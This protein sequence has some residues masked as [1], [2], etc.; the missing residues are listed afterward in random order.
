MLKFVLLKWDEVE[1]EEEE[2]VVI[3]GKREKDYEGSGVGV[4]WNLYSEIYCVV[5]CISCGRNNI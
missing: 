1:E 4:L 5:M 2:L 3:E